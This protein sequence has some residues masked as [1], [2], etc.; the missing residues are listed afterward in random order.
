[1]GKE[2][3]MR[4][5]VI[6]EAV[7]TGYN[8]VEDI[9]RR[10]YNPIIL[11]PAGEPGEE[12]E[13][14]R[15][16][17]YK[18]YYR[19]PK[20]LRAP[21]DYAETLA[22]VKEYDP[23]LVVAGSENGVILATRLAADLGLPGNPYEN[24][25]FM[26]RKDAMQEALKAA[27]MRY[28]RGRNVKT[29]EEALQF[30]RENGFE[31]AVIKPRQSA[32]SQ[33]VFLCDDLDQVK[34]AVNTL[35][36]WKDFYGRQIESVIV[37]ERIVGTEY[38]VNT[39]SCKGIHKLNSILRYSKEKTA[40]GGYIYDYAESISRLEAGHTEL[41]EYALKT[42]D[43]MGIQYGIVHGEYM[44]DEKGPVLIEV[45]CR[46]MGCSMPSEYLDLV[47][48]QHE[49][50]TLLD[51]YLDE[52]GFMLD[53][54]KPYRPLRKCVLKMIIV[55][56]DMEAEN[57]PIWAVAS[58]LR[59]TYKISAGENGVASYYKKTRD[60]ESSGG[61]IFLVHDDE[62]VVLSDLAFLRE[63]EKKYFSFLLNDGMSRKWFIDSNVDRPDF[64]KIIEECGCRGAI[65]AVSDEEWHKDGVQTVTPGTIDDSHKGFDYVIIG[66][67]KSLLSLS[68]SECLS[69]IF[70]I[71]DRVRP[72][73][74]VIV[75]ANTYEY[76]SYKKEGAE[77]LLQIK[78]LHIEQPLM[79][80]KGYVI[81]SSQ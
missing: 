77:L 41:V 5:I 38:I 54:E 43:A 1:M 14:M 36:T 56:E 70:S 80:R 48:G 69:L 31:T 49:T 35:L 78:G 18:A 71:I 50:D 45:N 42:A 76:L 59:S 72:G 33:G 27:G 63:I 40:E 52:K 57:H 21:D 20:I 13:K 61:V 3:I 24:I 34:D 74:R 2:N 79:R 15:N 55:P 6:V 8:L 60:L 58:Q 11:E 30:C 16:S 73:G 66:L 19:T 22:L 9:V 29:V 39:V 17:S 28:I 12:I 51:S 37:Q 25:E 7:S 10:G 44:V 26:T 47:F 62:N 53:L 81:G 67:Q 23:L 68:E 65:L 75:P 32:G 64:E 46:P 4:N